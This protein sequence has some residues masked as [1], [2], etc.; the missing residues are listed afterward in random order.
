MSRILVTGGAG[1]VGSNLVNKLIQVG[2]SVT[3][4]DDFSNGLVS[5]VEK[6]IPL[7][8]ADLSKDL[9]IKELAGEKFNV[10]IHCA[11]Q[12]SNATSFKN[13]I[14][15]ANANQISTLQVLKYCELESIDRLIFTSSMSVYGN[16]SIFPTP[17]TTT[18]NP[19]TYYALHKATSE[20]YLRLSEN[21]NWTIFRL[22]TTY[23]A[24]QNLLNKEQGLVK[25]F[26]N[27]ILDGV[28]VRVHGSGQRVRDI[29]HVRDVVEAIHLSIFNNKT[30][31]QI[32]NLGSGQ[33]ITV[34]HIINSLYTHMQ[35]NKKYDVI[36]EPADIGDPF[37]T[38]A[39][40]Y[41]TKSD[42]DWSPTITPEEGIELTASKYR[43]N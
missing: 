5:N 33:T 34:D 9:W 29:I 24:G 19:E 7:L 27:Y 4:V 21:I 15:D 30:H 39:D 3:I 25:I 10:V 40:I 14:L 16:Q 2:H 8:K 12:A 17:P 28:P 26:L 43:F 11:A 37:K 32:Y 38:H 23:G 42:L 13:P 35:L 6:S 31:K 22:Y 20:T 36:Y 41:S 1:F 18:P